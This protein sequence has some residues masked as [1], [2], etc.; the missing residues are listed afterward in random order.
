MI[1]KNTQPNPPNTIVRASAGSGK[2][3]YLT[4]KFIKLLIQGEPASGMLATTFTRAAAGEVMHRVLERLSNAVIDPESLE[5]LRGATEL[6]TLTSEKCADVLASLISQLNRLSIVTIDSFFSRMASSFSLELGLPMQYQLIEEE[7]E[8]ILKEQCVDQAIADATTAEMVEL[9]R[10][11]QG[12]R[13]Q[14]GTHETIMKLIKSAYAMY[15]AT[16][17]HPEPWTSIQPVGKPLKAGDFEQYID[18][19]L[20]AGVPKTK[21]G[22]PNKNWVKALDNCIQQIRD[23]DWHS[24]FENGLGKVVGIG[25]ATGSYPTYSKAEINEELL[26]PLIPMIDHARHMVSTE[27]V[28]RTKAIYELMRRFD[29]VYRNTKMKSGQITFDDPPR[30]LNESRVTGDLDH[31]YY[32]LDASIRH[33]MLDEFQD[34]SMPQFKLLEPILDE[35][36]SQ[37]E[38]DRS[39]F[40]VGDE[41][42]SL[43]SWRQAEP[44]LLGAMSQR[45]ENFNEET[46]AKSWRSSPIVLDAVNEVFG[47]LLNNDVFKEDEKDPNPVAIKAAINWKEQ[48]KTHRAA[49]KDMPGHVVLKVAEGD[50]DIHNKE[51][52]EEVL[53][54]CANSVQEAK[55]LAPNASIAILVRQGKYIYPLLTRLAKLGV[56]ACEDRGNPLVDSPSVA[57]AVSMLKLIDH[58]SDTAALHHVRSTPLGDYLQLQTPSRVHALASNLRSRI[59]RE[60]CV[61]M[62]TQWLS[63]CSQHMDKRSYIRF[64]QLIELA[65]KL[66]DEG[67]RDAATL[68]RIAETRKIDEPGHTPVRVLTIHKSKG[69]EFDV[70]VL[71]LLGDSWRVRPDSIPASRDHPLG[72]ITQVSRYPKSGL[73][74]IHPELKT[75]HNHTLLTQINEELCCLYVAMTRAKSSLQMIVPSDKAGRM[76]APAK[77]FKL[78]PAHVIRAALAPDSPCT[79][80]SIL[81]ER[82]TQIDWSTPITNKPETPLKQ[83]TKP[84]EL[85]IQP[86]KSVDAGHLKSLTP[87]K[88]HGSTSI[89][90]SSILEHS[91]FGSTARQYGECLHRGFEQ[92]D[93]LDSQDFDLSG[94]QS[95]LLQIGYP[96]SMVDSVIHEINS[97][98]SAPTKIVFDQAS[99]INNSPDTTSAGVAHEQAFAVRLG[100]QSEDRLVQGRFD[101]LVLGR[102]NHGKVTT[103][104]IVDYKTDR[105]AKGLSDSELI[106]F[107]NKHQAQM[108]LYRQA[109]AKMYHTDESKVRVSLVF[110][111]TPGIVDL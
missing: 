72:P 2:T 108:V 1:A 11:M 53:W 19:A 79:P 27:H 25:L 26:T 37:N 8:K 97:T 32:R 47:D 52:V 30:L 99:W 69:L 24:L 59:V 100:H 10:S 109:A 78:Y 76:N 49:K 80:G 83:P 107:A 54:A 5:E 71:P 9:I 4:S 74:I 16:G 60:G 21:K 104:H 85:R 96:Q 35:L 106:E 98:L 103:I 33:V 22:E 91:G 81:Y 50:E 23:H 31:L 101:R 3:F 77:S 29:S 12:D 15:L 17:G 46:L 57:V 64:N 105:A 102:D 94:I 41:K 75:L 73:Q 36:L 68:A 63:A 40:I 43:Y 18:D 56:E 93:W 7:E 92:I 90:A 70:V 87:S 34:T 89:N 82:S 39:V 6:P 84:I 86:P 28:E 58:P 65:G 55:R 110:T 66:Q 44:K 61:P 42:Q 88:Q 67:K 48:Y 62:L 20:K 14:M 95:E 111:A 38:E 13:I 51:T 45:W